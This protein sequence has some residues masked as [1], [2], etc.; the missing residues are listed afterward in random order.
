MPDRLRSFRV[1]D[2]IWDAAQTVAKQRGDNVSEIL[3]HALW[4]YVLLFT[5]QPSNIDG[6]PQ[7]DQPA[8]STADSATPADSPRP[9]R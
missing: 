4:G 1:P 7:Q 3:R 8:D 2:G 9:H 5:G 6:T